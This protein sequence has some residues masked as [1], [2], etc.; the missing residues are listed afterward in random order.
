MTVFAGAHMKS[1]TMTNPL[2]EA[3]WAARTNATPT[4][5]ALSW[6]NA[7]PGTTAPIASA[8]TVEQVAELARGARLT[9]S[10]ADVKELT[11]AGK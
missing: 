1:K 10:A 5:I 2:T 6:L 3:T 7:Q 9:L 4:E 8:T 11:D